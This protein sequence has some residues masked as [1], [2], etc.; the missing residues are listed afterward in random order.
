M[1]VSMV[2]VHTVVDQELIDQ[3]IQELIDQAC[4]EALLTWDTKEMSR[5]LCMSTRTIEDDFL[6]DD[7]MRVLQ[8][9]KK[10]G[11]RYWFYEPSLKV[12]KQIMDEW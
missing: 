5:R 10:G 3:R 12:I 4:R 9:Q 2:Q 11:K 7:R 6:K 1:S 8:R